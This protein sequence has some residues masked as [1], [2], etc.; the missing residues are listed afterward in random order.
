MGPSTQVYNS[1]DLKQIQLDS[2]GYLM[3]RHLQS[4]AHFD[5]SSDLFD[6]A[7]RFYGGN[8]KEVSDNSILL[9]DMINEITFVMAVQCMGA[10]S[11]SVCG[12]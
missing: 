8:Y 1:L 10:K 7:L 5:S 4:C 12:R 3:A 2:L 9:E 6:N 11:A